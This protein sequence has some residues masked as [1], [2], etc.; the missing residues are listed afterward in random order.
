MLTAAADYFNTFQDSEPGAQQPLLRAAASV[1]RYA[2][3]RQTTLEQEVCGLRQQV[4]D[5]QDSMA[6]MRAHI[7]LPGR[8]Q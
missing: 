3:Q 4:A 2:V 6:E 7:G 5:M 8:T 1:S